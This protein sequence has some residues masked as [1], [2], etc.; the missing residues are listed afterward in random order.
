M[1]GLRRVGGI[2]AQGVVPRALAPSSL[3]SNSLG[4]IFFS[5]KLL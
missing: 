4:S 1:K 5:F 3:A 2:E